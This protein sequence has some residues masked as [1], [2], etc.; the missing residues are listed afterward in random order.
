MPNFPPLNSEA[1]IIGVG[2]IST[3]PVLHRKQ[4]DTFYPQTLSFPSMPL[5]DSM[6]LHI[7]VSYNSSTAWASFDGRGHIE[8]KREI[9]AE[10]HH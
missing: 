6:E 10:V 8:P 9:I 2:Y 3:P 5:S 4:I 7:R 1:P